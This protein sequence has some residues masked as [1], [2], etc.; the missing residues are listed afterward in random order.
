[1][2]FGFSSFFL[3]YIITIFLGLLMGYYKDGYMDRA[4][5]MS[6]IIFSSV[7]SLLVSIMLILFFCS[8]YGLDILPLAY[9]TS[10]DYESLSTTGKI[11]DRAKHFILPLASYM[12]G[13]FT[14]GTLILRSKIL[15]EYHQDYYKKSAL[16][17]ALYRK[18]CGRDARLKQLEQKMK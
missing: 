3:G 9:L 17:Y 2:Q 18:A 10:D 11:I 1:M 4:M 12:L 13:S 15:E 16:R 8:D 7:P 14:V 6:L 5:K